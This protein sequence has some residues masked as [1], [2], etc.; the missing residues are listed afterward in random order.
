MDMQRGLSKAQPSRSPCQGAI[1]V[2]EAAVSDTRGYSTYHMNTAPF[3]HPQSYKTEKH[4][5]PETRL[6]L[7]NSRIEQNPLPLTPSYTHPF[8]C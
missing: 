2:T 1:H 6:R 5:K 3:L 8:T 4:K 7:C